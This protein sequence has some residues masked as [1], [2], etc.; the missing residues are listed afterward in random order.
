[1][2]EFT[3]CLNTIDKVK[4]FVKIVSKFEQNMDIII[5]RYIVDAKSI[6]GIFSIDLT[7]KLTLRIDSNDINTCN[8]I[9]EE[10]KEFIVEGN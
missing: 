4:N 3:I 9:R 5:G 7:R 6:M 10:L 1:M 2:K 8:E